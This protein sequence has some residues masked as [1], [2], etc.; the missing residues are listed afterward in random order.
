MPKRLTERFPTGTVVEIEIT[1]FGWLTGIVVK[2]APPA[3]WVRTENGQYWFVTNGRKIRPLQ[4][5]ED[6]DVHDID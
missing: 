6:D 2:H 3:V 1:D 4:Q 5:N